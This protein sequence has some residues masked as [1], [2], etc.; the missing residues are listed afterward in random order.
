MIKSK[1]QGILIVI[2]APSG[3]G[4]GTVIKEMCNQNSNLWVSVSATS[5]PMRTNDEEGKTYYFITEEDFKQKIWCLW[6]F[7][8]YS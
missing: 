4:K 5:R 3:A 2:S 1:K 6:N 7:W 8:N